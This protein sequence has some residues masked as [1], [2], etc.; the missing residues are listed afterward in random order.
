MLCLDDAWAMRGLT[1]GIFKRN[2]MSFSN[3]GLSAAH[4]K[5]T[6][7]GFF[8]LRQGPECGILGPGFHQ[9]VKS[10]QIFTP[11]V[12]RPP[13]VFV[14]R[15]FNGDDSNFVVPVDAVLFDRTPVGRYMFGG[16]FVSSS[17]SRWN[18]LAEIYGATP[19]H[20]RTES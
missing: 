6:V 2:G 11:E 19:L 7:I 14:L 12:Y 15:T 17:D 16:C 3:G 1:V 4:D 18:E 20:D 5:L 8:D 13:A 9:L 10:S